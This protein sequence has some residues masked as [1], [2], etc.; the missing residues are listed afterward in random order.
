MSQ[1]WTEDP[2]IGNA[3]AGLAQS[4][5][6]NRIED[7]RKKRA[8]RQAK[9]QYGQ[10]YAD[11]QE[12][13]RPTDLGVNLPPEW[14]GSINLNVPTYQWT[15]PNDYYDR[16]RALGNATAD[17]GAQ[18]S[19]K[20]AADASAVEALDQLRIQGVPSTPTGQT[21]MQTQLTG[22]LPM[23]DLKGTTSNYA[24]Q[25]PEGNIVAKGTTRDGRTDMA[26]AQPIQVPTGH[27]LVKMGDVSADQSPFKDK[28]AELSALER[29]N[30]QATLGDKPFGL[31]ELQRSAI[32]L[33]S[34]FPQ[35]QKVEKD[36]AGNIRVVGYNEK[37]I[38]GVYG[39]LVAKIN[40]ELFGQQPTAAPPP[41]TAP[42]ALPAAPSPTMGAA[43]GQRATAPDALAQV[44]TTTAPA[45]PAATKPIV[46]S[47]T[48]S[49]T[50]VS[51]SAPVIQGA[52][53]EQ[54][55]EILN[56]PT[57]KGAMD[58]GRAYN[59]L[60]AASQA[61]TP[62]ADLHMIYMLAKIYDPNSVVR[63]GEVATAANTSPA[64]EKWWG[65][66]NKQMNASS[67]LSDR[68]RASFLDEGYK[69]ATAHY[70]QAKGLIDYASDRAGRL[71]LDPRNAVP[72]LSAPTPPAKQEAPAKA[73]G[74]R[75]AAPAP[76]RPVEVTPA[77]REAIAWA[78][79]N[80][81]DPR[82]T[83]IL[84]RNGLQ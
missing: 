72:P 19:M 44:A 67:A 18:T 46:P 36:D 82:A 12:A 55:K 7:M 50:G 3:L 59:E 42:N 38:P 61:K 15:N 30:R 37:A 70:Q 25:D 28:G 2:A 51:V 33:N 21:I 5:D 6:V 27:S 24:V 29:L 14:G 78:R 45:S 13:Q 1:F 16:A 47:G 84:R 66:Y 32:L 26:T 74:A 73:T 17:L 9:A 39:P 40:A 31:S 10:A 35:A 69:A 52:G 8:E 11:Y 76:T 58:A 56:H 53:D 75:T 34:Q 54:L 77:D 80:P 20:N 68:A 49:S 60:L 48:I 71:G 81:K 57:V 83:D 22:Q 65:L 63:E 64:M 4:F 41:P 62:E 43:P 23:L 79:A